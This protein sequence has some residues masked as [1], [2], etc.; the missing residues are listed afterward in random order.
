MT[1]EQ[2]L[3]ELSSDHEVGENVK[4]HIDNLFELKDMLKS[5]MENDTLSIY[6]IDMSSLEQPEVRRLNFSAIDIMTYNNISYKGTTERYPFDGEPHAL[7]ALGDSQEM[8]ARIFPCGPEYWNANVLGCWINNNKL[9]LESNLFGDKEPS[10][11]QFFL[12]EYNAWEHYVDWMLNRRADYTKRIDILI[13]SI[14]ETNRLIDYST[15]MREVAYRQMAAKTDHDKGYH[16]GYRAALSDYEKRLASEKQKTIAERIG[17]VRKNIADVKKRFPVG[18]CFAVNNSETPYRVVFGYE[19]DIEH[20]YFGCM[21]WYD[22]GHKWTKKHPLRRDNC[23]ILS[24]DKIISDPD[25]IKVIT[26][27]TNK[28]LISKSTEKKI[29]KQ[30]DK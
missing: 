7:V 21:Y 28:R 20:P 9:Y 5:K 26:S 12:N 19:D 16:D 8:L 29:I 6:V 2:V 10:S 27:P 13:K 23:G 11:Y 30:L 25:M 15:M 22:L 14:K 18:S 1:K 3:K 24:V 4:K 17:E